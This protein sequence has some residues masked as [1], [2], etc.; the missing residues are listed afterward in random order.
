[1]KAT[2]SRAPGDGLESTPGLR[3]GDDDRF[4]LFGETIPIRPGVEYEFSVWARLVDAPETTA[5]YIDWLDADFRELTRE[6]NAVEAGDSIGS[7]G[8]AR[9]A[10]RSTAPD[11]AAYAVPTVFKNGSPGAVVIDEL[12]F[13]E[14]ARCPDLAG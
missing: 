12:V 8:G 11:D 14:A 3:V 6:R 7:D 5:I 1:M 4:G 10:V 13:G 9:V 2:V